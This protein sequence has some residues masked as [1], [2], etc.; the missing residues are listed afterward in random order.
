M[1]NR[2]VT[3]TTRAATLADLSA[4]TRI[5]N[6]GIEDRI[7]TLEL[8]PKSEAEVSDWLFADRSG[9]YEVLVAEADDGV[10]GWASLRPYSH[11]CAY[12]GVADLSIYVERDARGRG[13][14]EQL[15][16]SLEERARANDFHKIVLFALR[17]N[18]AGRRLY[19]KRGFREVGVL[20]QQG[21]MDGSFVDVL[22]MEK[23]LARPNS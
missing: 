2:T 3:V 18:D 4:I 22:I 23:I 11:R 15:L 17:L 8:D 6:Q 13:V 10:V 12:A 7:A 16:A 1:S 20:E 19:A 14:G 9:R 21:T 5:Y